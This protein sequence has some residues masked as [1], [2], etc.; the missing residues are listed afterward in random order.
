MK[1]QNDDFNN[2]MLHKIFYCSETQ[3]NELGGTRST[4]ERGKIRSRHRF[5][6]KGCTKWIV[7]T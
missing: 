4:K 5:K 6:W 2:F 3:E 1:L 7:R